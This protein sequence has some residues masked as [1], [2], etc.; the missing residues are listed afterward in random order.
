MWLFFDA[1]VL[2]CVET[3]CSGNEISPLFRGCCTSKFMAIS[4]KK[5]SIVQFPRDFSDLWR[6]AISGAS[7]AH[8]ECGV[9]SRSG[10]LWTSLRSLAC[11]DLYS[12]LERAWIFTNL[13]YDLWASVGMGPNGGCPIWWPNLWFLGLEFWPIPYWQYFHDLWQEPGETF[14]KCVFA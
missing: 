1:F 9:Q 4:I 3:F 5:T 13:Y 12:S 14:A 11:P 8:A 7:V 6:A 10:I 2:I